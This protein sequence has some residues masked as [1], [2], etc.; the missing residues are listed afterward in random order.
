MS[1][2]HVISFPIDGQRFN[3]RVAAIIVADDHVLICRED[4]DDYCMLP[5]GR[6]ELGEDSRLSLTREIA[7]ELAL[8]AD[9][10][11]LL[12]TSESFYR[13]EDQDFHEVG[14]FYR[15]DLPGQAPDG[16]SPWLKRFDEGHDLSFHWVPLAGD[17][18]ESYNLLPAWLPEFLRRRTGELTHVVDDKRSRA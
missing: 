13:R 3:F 16:K 18:L 1:A 4:D 2:R 5:G 9:V 10:G 17:A 14:F 15:V 6:V 12:A 11:A 8:P 7:E